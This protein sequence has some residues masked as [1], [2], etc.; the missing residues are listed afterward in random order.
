MQ[1]V[2]HKKCTN[3]A[4]KENVHNKG[5]VRNVARHTM[6][7]NDNNGECENYERSSLS[8]AEVSVKL[9]LPSNKRSCK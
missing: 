1:N 4:Y 5:V 2:A 8:M 3:K 7:C 9:S 6:K